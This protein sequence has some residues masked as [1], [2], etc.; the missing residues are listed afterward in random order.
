M[1]QSLFPAAVRRLLPLLLCIMLLPLTPAAAG[2]ENVSL[3][4]YLKS[5]FD[6]Q[7]LFDAAGKALDNGADPKTVLEEMSAAADELDALEYLDCAIGNIMA[8]ANPETKDLAKLA[9]KRKL[10][11]E[12]SSDY[13]FIAEPRYSVYD[14]PGVSDSVKAMLS[15]TKGN[16]CLEPAFWSESDFTKIFKV[17]P[18]QFKPAEPRPAHVCVV[19]RDK[20]QAAPEEKW[21]NDLDAITETL[22]QVL[23]DLTSVLED[24]RPVYTGNPQLASSLWIIEIRYSLRGRYGEEGK[25]KGYNI[26]LT[27]S[28]LDTKTHK[29]TAELKHTE[30]LPDTIWEWD[31]WIAKAELP[32]IYN[33][34]DYMAKFRKWAKAVRPILKQERSSAAAGSRITAHNAEKVLNALLVRQTEK[35]SDAWQKAIYTAG[36]KNISL[37]DGSLSFTLRGF[38]PKL[39]DLGARSKAEDPEQWLQTALENASEYNLAFSLSLQEGTVPQTEINALKASVQKAAAAAKSAFGSKDMTAALKDELFPLPYD[40]EL[41]SSSQLRTP[42]EAFAAWYSRR[43]ILPGYD[44]P[45][46]V[47]ASVMAYR[48][49]QNVN[50]QGGPHAITFTCA[51]ESLKELGSDS[52]SKV[53]D[54]Q[55]F[56][57]ASEREVNDPQEALVRALSIRTVSS[58]KKVKAKTEISVDLDTL[59]GGSLPAEYKQMFTEF[60]WEDLVEKLSDTLGSLPDEAAKE[61]PKNGIIK[62]GKSGTTVVFRAGDQ[63]Y[64][65]YLIMRETSTDKVAVSAMLYPKKSVTVRVP[66]GKYEIAW[67]SGPYWFGT[68]VLFGAL[69]QYNKSETVKIRDKKYRHTFTLKASKNDGV[70][71]YDANPEDFR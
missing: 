52:I 53:T 43:S 31:N 44:V 51:G 48:K 15:K 26:S 69:G 40:G 22:E 56:L 3:D 19:I 32:G 62:G 35:L 18:E 28:A 64:P 7:D 36:A 34:D 61:M 46:P 47:A 5:G 63:V 57:P 37:E 13:E 4:D 50:V 17:K 9:G 55:A 20:T 41:T 49:V 65:T 42:S 8:D 14:T 59:T 33:S 23:N 2:D 27:L 38:D 60:R 12:T 68:K 58:M 21:K 1:K 66:K 54:E 39:N 6:M 71:F 45:C 67:C 30:V 24:D 10:S 25:I 70:S 29:Q 11:I 16:A